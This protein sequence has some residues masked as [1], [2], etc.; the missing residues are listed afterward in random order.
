[1]TISLKIDDK[2][3][4]LKPFVEEFLANTIKGMLSALRD[5]E[6]PNIVEIKI[7]YR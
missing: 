6:N 5:C 1:M 2:E 7:D 4:P 3:I